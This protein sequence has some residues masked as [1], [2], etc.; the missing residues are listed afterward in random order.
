MSMVIAERFGMAEMLGDYFGLEIELENIRDDPKERLQVMKDRGILHVDVDGSL[1]NNGME[2]ITSPLPFPFEYAE[3]SDTIF[4][5]YPEAEASLRCGIHVHMNV[6]DMTYQ[7]LARLLS[8][9]CL[10]ERIIF[11]HTGNRDT[12]H[13]CVPV[14]DT[15]HVMYALYRMSEDHVHHTVRSSHKYS[16]LNIKP[17]SSLGTVEARHL[18]ASYWRTDV[19]YEL[20]QVLRNLKHMAMDK[21]SKDQFKQMIWDINTVSNYEWFLSKVFGRGLL[22]VDNMSEENHQL[23]R[24]E[25][26]QFKCVNK[27]EL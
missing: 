23:L 26:F 11:K 14:T 15:N 25:V 27:G 9:Y 20:V 18:P 24:T 13:F 22:G 10:V 19:P 8:L 17:V 5:S 21:M 16:A 2:F 3:I 1:R 4:D 7:Q 12:N 6:R